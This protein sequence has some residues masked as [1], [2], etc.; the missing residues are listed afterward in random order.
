MSEKKQLTY[1][2]SI[3]NLIDYGVN[4]GIKIDQ[5]ESS[6]TIYIEKIKERELKQTQRKKKTKKKKIA[7]PPLFISDSSDNDVPIN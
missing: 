5:I 7:R 1:I 2:K 4:N 6:L 3:I